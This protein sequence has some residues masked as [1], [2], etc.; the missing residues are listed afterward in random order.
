VKYA[1][2]VDFG[3][4]FMVSSAAFP[5]RNYQFTLSCVPKYFVYRTNRWIFFKIEPIFLNALDKGSI[6]H[7]WISVRN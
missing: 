5:L 7:D 6:Q 3:L 2:E 4:H 1:K